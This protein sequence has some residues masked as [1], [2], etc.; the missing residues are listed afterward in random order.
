MAY[1]NMACIRCFSEH[2]DAEILTEICHAISSAMSVD[3]SHPDY[4]PYIDVDCIPTFFEE[5]RTK[6]INQD[7]LLIIAV[8]ECEKLAPYLKSQLDRKSILATLQ[9]YACDQIKFIFTSSSIEEIKILFGADIDLHEI[10]PILIG[11]LSKEKTYELINASYGKACQKEILSKIWKLT[12]GQPYLIQA[13]GIAIVEEMN[14]KGDTYIT[15]ND[16]NSLVHSASFFETHRNIHCFF[17]CVINDLGDW[18]TNK[19]I[20][21]LLAH[22]DFGLSAEKLSELTHSH[23]VDIELNELKNLDLI[24]EENDVFTIKPHLFSIWLKRYG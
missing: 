24:H 16:F 7:K 14:K 20:L 18:S 15:L 4:S 21:V 1:S 9:E 5:V 22:S 13:M 10:Y 19:L 2:I 23:F 11:N 12:A 3:L 8:D 17:S 6:L